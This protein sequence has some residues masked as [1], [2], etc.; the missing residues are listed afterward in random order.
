MASWIFVLPF[1]V[2]KSKM[3][4]DS[5]ADKPLYKNA[6]DC[7][8]KTFGEGGMVRFFRGFWLLSVRAFIVNGITFLVYENLMETCGG[9]KTN[10]SVNASDRSKWL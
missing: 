5:L 1:D 8:K 10:D 7:T 2:I 4:A 6:W 3:I 9:V